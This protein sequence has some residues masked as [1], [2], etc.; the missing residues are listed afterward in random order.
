MISVSKLVDIM[1]ILF[2]TWC[3]RI[4]TNVYIGC[5]YTQSITGQFFLWFNPNFSFKNH[6]CAP[7]VDPR[8]NHR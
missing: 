6:S 5:I 1:L 3:L 2:F 4:R 7:G 8:S